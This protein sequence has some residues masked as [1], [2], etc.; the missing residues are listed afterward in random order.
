MTTSDVLWCVPSDDMAPRKLLDADLVVGNGPVEWNGGVYFIAAPCSS[1]CPSPQTAAGLY[2]FDPARP[3]T[4][5]AAL[6]V[7]VES[8]TLGIPFAQLAADPAGLFVY[9]DAAKCGSATV[10][11]GR[12]SSSAGLRPVGLHSP[13]PAFSMARSSSVDAK[14]I[15]TRIC[16]PVTERRPGQD[17]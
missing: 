3:L 7:D 12:H 17:R 13:R 9:A 15:I 6:N 4:K 5:I 2:R 10:M 1:L 16:G 8:S 14:T 11:M